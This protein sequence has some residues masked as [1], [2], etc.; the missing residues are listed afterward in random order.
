MTDLQYESFSDLHLEWLGKAPL[1]IFNGQHY[2]KL[3]AIN[4]TQTK[5]IHGENFSG[6]LRGMIMKRIGNATRESFIQMN[7]NLKK[8]VE[9]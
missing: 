3:E 5:L 9:S 8:L 6:W 2:F 4:S 7:K 1:G